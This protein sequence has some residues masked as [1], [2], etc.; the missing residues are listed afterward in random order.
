MAQD[1]PCEAKSRRELHR[2]GLRSRTDFEHFVVHHAVIWIA[3]AELIELV[4]GYIE[5]DH[6]CVVDVLAGIHDLDQGRGHP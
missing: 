2:D 6:R 5:R 4:C 3:V 1:R